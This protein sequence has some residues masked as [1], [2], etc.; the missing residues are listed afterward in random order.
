MIQLRTLSLD[1]LPLMKEWM[2]D[3]E[4]TQYFRFN[5]YNESKVTQYIK[6]SLVDTQNRHFAIV[7]ANNT[8]LGTISLKNIDLVNKHAEYAIV[9]RKP[10]W[11]KGVGKQAS[12]LL[13]DFAKQI[14]MHK[15]YLNVLST[16]TS[17]IQLY[18]KLGFRKSGVY[19]DHILRDGRYHD[20]DYFEKIM[21]GNYEL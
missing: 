20:L 5:G 1:D 4:V 17:A 9:L 2:M 19:K 13:I 8:Y 10:F 11:G 21:G 18:E 3:K 15:I 16:N 7:D 6:D 12:L 14:G